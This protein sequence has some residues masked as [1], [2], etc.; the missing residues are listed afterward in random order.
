MKKPRASIYQS[1][2]DMQ[3][4]WRVRAANGETLADSGEGYKRSEK[5]EA[6]LKLVAEFFRASD[7]AFINASKINVKI[8]DARGFHIGTAGV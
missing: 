8:T 7:P 2:K 4:R 5:A 3:W 1:P 6:G